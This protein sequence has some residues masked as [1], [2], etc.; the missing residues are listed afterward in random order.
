MKAVDIA[1][2][3]L[4]R[5]FR[6]VSFLA[7]GLVVP[8]LV[9][10]LFYFAFRGISTEDGGWS[11]PPTTVQLV[12]LDAPSRE[13]GGLR[14]GVLLADILRSES[15]DELLHVAEAPDPEA[16]RAAVDRQRADVA[17]IIPVGF[18]QALVQPEEKARVEVYHDPTLTIGP[19]IVTGIVQQFVDGFAGAKIAADV[20]RSQLAEHGLALDPAQAGA[21]AQQFAGWAKGLADSEQAGQRPLVA[22]RT[23]QAG[24]AEADGSGLAIVSL[25]MS[26]MMAFFV[27]FT[28]ASTALTLLQEEEAGTLQRLFSTPTALSAILGGRIIAS[29]VTLLLQVVVLLV[30]SALVFG[31][32]WGEPLFI[33]LVT[34]GTILLAGSFGLFV[35][36]LL[37]DTRQGGIVIG[38]A[39]TI[40]G[41]VGMMSTFTAGAAAATQRPFEVASLVVPHGWAVRGWRQLLEG[42]G[43]GELWLSLAVMLALS[44]VFFGLALFRFRRRFA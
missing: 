31:I 2:K 35:I 27:F 36:S 6:S 8:L 37:K 13:A 11:L 40:A 19:S 44:G 29:L 21:L 14:G 42:G 30:V 7:F 10:G 5:A 15:L 39:M 24:D 3:D 25:I 41:M 43:A 26:G 22:V 18:T 23:A 20:G 9:S 4:L 34:V 33:V 32:D 17:V 16:A 28:G 12:N 38:G 1:L